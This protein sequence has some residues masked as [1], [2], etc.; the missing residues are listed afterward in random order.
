MNVEGVAGH[1]D[2]YRDEYRDADGCLRHDD[3]DKDG[4][5]LNALPLQW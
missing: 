4:A 2:E 3:P 5:I 1:A